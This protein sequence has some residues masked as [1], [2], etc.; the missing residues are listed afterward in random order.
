MLR[1]RFDRLIIQKWEN[2][3]DN[4]KFCLINYIA[5]F[6]NFDID[7]S[8]DNNWYN[9]IC[10]ANKSFSVLSDIQNDLNCIKNILS[11]NFA[12]WIHFL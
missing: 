11:L 5:N 4:N 1:L 6:T 9:Y 7:N 3:K 10:H 8:R 2:Y 12:S